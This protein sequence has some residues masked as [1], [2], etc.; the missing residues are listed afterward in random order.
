MGQNG[1]LPADMTKPDVSR[2]YV[3]CNAVYMTTNAYIH[4]IYC[5]SIFFSQFRAMLVMICV[6]LGEI[7]KYPPSLRNP[8]NCNSS[9]RGKKK[10]YETD[11]G[12]TQ[13]F[14]KTSPINGLAIISSQFSSKSEHIFFTI[15][16]L[17]FP[18]FPLFPLI[19]PNIQ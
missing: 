6:V 12:S 16:H 3:S 4:Y 7:D 19:F 14:E 5:I 9:Q 13:I 11:R 1:G 15:F 8:E 10:S 17:I 2:G 18:Y